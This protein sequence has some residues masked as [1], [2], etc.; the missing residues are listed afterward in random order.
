M[1]QISKDFKN[2]GNSCKQLALRRRYRVQREKNMYMTHAAEKY[3]SVEQSAI[4]FPWQSV[5]GHVR[6]AAESLSYTINNTRRRCGRFCD[7]GA[8]VQMSRL[9]YLLPYMRSVKIWSSENFPFY[10]QI[11]PYMPAAH[12]CFTNAPRWRRGVTVERRTRDREVV[13]SSLGR[14][15]RRKNSGQVSHAYG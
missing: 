11:L 1:V 10:L 7:S 15:L 9:T 14:A 13:G 4:C 5:T 12:T 8:D 6:S 3:Y 2:N